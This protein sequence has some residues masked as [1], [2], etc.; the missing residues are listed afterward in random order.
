LP[1]TVSTK[2]YV[3]D[4][5]GCNSRL[6]T[7]QAAILNVKLHHL[8]DYIHQRQV[9]AKR[10]YDGLSGL[11][12]IVLPRKMPYSS[13]VYHQ[14]TVKVIDGRRDELKHY[15]SEYGIPCMIYYPRPLQQQNAFKDIA[16]KGEELTTSKELCQ[17]VLS[18]P[19]HTELTEEMQTYII[20]KIR[21]YAEQ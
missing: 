14:F 20:E 19:M 10:Y 9:A 2:K 7:I 5:I 11:E 17:Q 21:E 15:L 3:H 8:N 16:R 18:L 1:A 4:V 13:H 6:D 12:S